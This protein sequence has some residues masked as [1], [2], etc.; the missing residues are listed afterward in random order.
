MRRNFPVGI[1]AGALLATWTGA[2]WDIAWHGDIGRDT[3][4]SPPHILILSGIS[5]AGLASLWAVL[6]VGGLIRRRVEA[7]PAM[8][9]VGVVAALQV[10]GLAVDNWWHGVFGLDVTLWSPPHVL[11]IVVG[12]FGVLGVISDHLNRGAP[13]P[14]VRAG[15]AGVVL[16][17][18][19]LVLAEYEFGFPHYRL[20][21]S[22]LLLAAV[23]GGALAMARRVSGLRWAGT[24]AVVV[25]LGLRLAGIGFHALV[26]RS[27]PSFPLGIALSGLVFDLVLLRETKVRRVP[28]A[29]V[30]AWVTCF[31]IE[32]PWLRATGKTWWPSAILLLALAGGA[33]AALAGAAIGWAVGG[34]LGGSRTETSVSGRRLVAAAA[35]GVV[36][37]LAAPA[38]ADAPKE[39]R[40]VAARPAGFSLRQGVARLDVPGAARADWATVFRVHEGHRSWSLQWMGG[41]TWNR[42]YLEGRL[43]RVPTGSFVV[44]YLGRDEAW[45]QFFRFDTTG[46]VIEEGEPMRWPRAVEGSGELTLYKA[47]AGRP[48][49]VAPWLRP[50][51]YVVMLVTL[52]AGAAAARSLLRRAHG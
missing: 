9:L 10:A 11:V 13:R 18:S 29:V 37:V 49:P 31:A 20:I 47:E 12:W 22:P 27:L 28:V 45:T 23:L 8:V 5:A 35:L 3:F 33:I 52:A 39:W 26:G 44:W 15:W 19:M 51:G 25:A 40:A 36:V 46:A 24:I 6:P 48:G 14:A 32:L 4:W 50:A 43:R 38:V 7:R 2:M 41:L 42:D 30:A 21:W 34:A 1:A 17:L 16:T